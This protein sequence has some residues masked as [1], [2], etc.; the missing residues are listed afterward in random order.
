MAEIVNLRE[1]RKA[2]TRAKARKTAD[3]NAMRFGRSKGQKAREAA[4][5]A[6]SKAILDGAKRDSDQD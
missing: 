5:L 6:R 4:D 1:T 3:E 2:V